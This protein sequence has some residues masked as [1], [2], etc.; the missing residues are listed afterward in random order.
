MGRPLQALIHAEQG[1][2]LYDYQKR[3]LA[4]NSRFKIGMM[5]RQCGKTFTTTLE[6]VMDCLEAEA[7]GQ[8][9]R[10]VIL[11]RGERQAREAMEEGIKRHFGAF[12][13]A[14][15][16]LEYDW[17]PETKAR[18]RSAP[19]GSLTPAYDS[20][21]A[22]EA[23]LSV[24][25]EIS[26]FAVE[27]S[28][29]KLPTVFNSSKY[30]GLMPD[31]S[32]SKLISRI[33]GLLQKRTAAGVCFGLTTAGA[34]DTTVTPAALLAV[35]PVPEHSSLYVVLISGVIFL[36]PNGDTWPIPGVMVHPVAFWE[37][38]L[39]MTVCPLVIF[40]GVAVSAAVGTATGV[41]GGST[42]LGTTGAGAGTGADSTAFT[43][44]TAPP[45]GIYAPIV[46]SRLFMVCEL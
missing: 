40:S 5:S 26:P 6:I 27:N 21:S 2:V 16:S 45:K 18:S 42:T 20:I 1:L 44:G 19:D 38:Q 46:Y 32:V 7:M 14:F 41:G 22:G 11:S 10:W 8:R 37:F 30:C 12:K 24:W 25:P 36:I 13:M 9:R 34:G 33:A 28:F 4:D 29:K 15:E 23:V 43:A 17:N 39:R 3:W 31:L 35:P